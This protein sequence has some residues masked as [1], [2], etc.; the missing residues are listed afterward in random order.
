[1]IKGRF[2]V[3]LWLIIALSFPQ[4][5]TIRSANAMQDFTVEVKPR[6]VSARGAYILHLTLGKALEVHDWIKVR[7]PE[8]TKL[9][10]LST[11][12]ERRR[13]ELKR[14][15]ESI[16]IGSSPCSSCQG[17]PELNYAE[18]SIR[19]NVH[20]GLD[21]AIE[22]YE[23]IKIT[24]TDRVGLINPDKAGWYQLA[25]S[26]A[27]EP[28]P[29]KSQKYEIVTSRIGDPAGIPKAEFTPSTSNT[30]AKTL[31]RFNLGRGGALTLNQSRIR[32][33]F[34]PET[35]FSK[36][37]DSINP[38][39]VQINNRPV[40]V[41]L[42]FF[43]NMLTVI[44]PINL[45]NGAQVE[46]VI[47]PEAGLINP[48]KAGSYTLHVSSSE[49]T[50]W[51][52]SV[53]YSIEK[54][55]PILKVIPDTI[56]SKASYE[57]S[58]LLENHES[59]SPEK[60]LSIFFPESVSLP[61]QINHTL[62]T[63]NNDP[64]GKIAIDRQTVLVYPSK[65]MLSEEHIIVHFMKEAG[66]KNPSLAQELRL[67]FSCFGSHAQRLSSP[68]YIREVKLHWLELEVNPPNA[69][70]TAS[71]SFTIHLG[72]NGKLDRGDDITITFPEG[73]KLDDQKTDPNVNIMLNDHPASSYSWKNRSLSLG[74][75]EEYTSE[76]LI[77][78]VVP[79]QL[80]IRNPVKEMQ[81]VSFSVQSTAEPE[82]VFSSD[83]FIPPALPKSSLEILRGKKGNQ[84]WYTETPII[85]ILSNQDEVTIYYWWDDQS[86]NRLTYSGPFVLDPGYYVSN[87]HYYAESAYG[88]ES[89]N[90]SLF[91]VDTIA[92]FFTIETPTAPWS[93][94]RQ[95]TY[96]IS[97][98]VAPVYL[99]KNG[100][101]ISIIDQPF[102]LNDL[103]VDLH[104]NGF[105]SI[106]YLLSEGANHIQFTCFDEAGNRSSREYVLVLDTHP[107][108]LHIFSPD[109]HQT[110]MEASFTVKGK[111]E[112]GA[113]LLFEGR[114]I[115]LDDAGF[116]EHL[117]TFPSNDKHDFSIEAIDPAGNST[118]IKLTLWGGITLLLQIGSS[119]CYVNQQAKEMD[120]A[121]LLIQGRSLVPLRLLA[122]EFGA[123]ISIESDPRSGSVKKVRYEL[124]HID[125]ELWIDQTTAMVNG[126]A[127]SLDVAPRIV[128]QRTMIPL[129]F[130]AENLQAKVDWNASS[131]SITI[132]YWSLEH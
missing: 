106:E 115:A 124:A 98:R 35:R 61:S 55:D 48:E 38:N 112:A 15:I 1:M 114:D 40:S 23:T 102:L 118:E 34:P 96:R 78:I 70:A 126:K 3:L 60:P 42:M 17:L 119:I 64:S 11:N 86:E 76:S 50:D 52:E 105:F 8:G 58:F 93:L 29:E 130:V 107:P 71:F 99:E 79:E 28:V 95:S 36:A 59:L 87:L 74:V 85:T 77:K 121:P 14:I 27:R 123:S 113:Q 56:G 72:S 81:W 129:R 69:G 46:L 24:F 131:Q 92:P 4:G 19:F 43:E 37:T 54:S 84:D 31:V 127:V 2:L 65:E 57:L 103:Q 90:S 125:I 20:L 13:E 101:L 16:Y 94:T 100:T 45:D 97:G 122:E 33:Q 7:F 41:R 6:R 73:S 22:G 91:K 66:I 9:P 30:N 75:S 88:K 82:A 47:S 116:F 67:A 109:N 39:Y 26:T 89:V 25:I 132:T 51:I 80:G 18:N 83:V 62:V 117:A 104:D 110:I 49:D 5:F 32:I 10:E 12:P 63:L 21:P 53:P 111:T 120:V 108:D 44:T 128:Q 68:Q